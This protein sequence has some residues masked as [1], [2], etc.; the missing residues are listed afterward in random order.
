MQ[1]TPFLTYILKRCPY[2]DSDS[3][4]CDFIMKFSPTTS[5][6]SYG[7]VP[8][9][10]TILLSQFPP[11]LLS[12]LLSNYTLKE[13]GF[14]TFECSTGFDSYFY[15]RREVLCCAHCYILRYYQDHTLNLHGTQIWRVAEG[16]TSRPDSSACRIL[17]KAEI[18]RSI[19]EITILFDTYNL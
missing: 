7:N 1:I 18:L 19:Y 10:H 8:L 14:H 17:P 6:T 9:S 12:S 4:W 3:Y 5:V 13:V 15:F 2:F 11:F 16:S